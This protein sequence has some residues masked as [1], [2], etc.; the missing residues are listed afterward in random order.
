MNWYQ[1][2]LESSLLWDEYRDYCND[3]DEMVD[4]K[5]MSFKRWAYDYWLMEIA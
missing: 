3:A 4:E 5:R 2:N 1:E